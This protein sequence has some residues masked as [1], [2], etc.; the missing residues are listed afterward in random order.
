MKCVD[1]QSTV[2]F[3]KHV[4]VGRLPD[5]R[6]MRSEEDRGQ[7]AG[8]RER[9]TQHAAQLEVAARSTECSEEERQQELSLDLRACQ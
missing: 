1:L 9:R 8:R 4:R 7:A 6:A 5:A 3:G 2:I